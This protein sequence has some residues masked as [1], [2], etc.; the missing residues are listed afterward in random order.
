MEEEYEET[1][2]KFDDVAGVDEAK[3]ELIEIVDFLNNPDKY[4]KVGA[5]IP[6]G[7]LLVGPPGT[8]KTLIARAVAGEEGVPFFQASGSEFNEKYVGVGASRVRK[9]FARAR[10]NAP[11]I[12]F[13]DEID[14][15]GS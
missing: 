4:S 14:S 1:A 8:G 3:S 7:A 11:S 5:K 2:V 12:I 15:V 9:L 13:I 6:K 10:K